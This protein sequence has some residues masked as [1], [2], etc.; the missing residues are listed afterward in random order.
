MRADE[1]EEILGD[2]PHMSLA[3]ARQI[4]EFIKNNDVRDILEL[5]FLPWRFNLLYGRRT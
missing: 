3:K 1:I 4:T 5:G 2:T